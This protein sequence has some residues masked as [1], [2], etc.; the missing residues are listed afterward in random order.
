MGKFQGA[1]EISIAKLNP[2]TKRPVSAFRFLGCVDSFDPKFAVQKGA[3][4]FERCSGLGLLDDQKIKS[5]SG[6]VDLTFTEWSTGNIAWMLNGGIVPQ[7]AP[8]VAAIETLPDDIVDGDQWHL[9]ASSGVTRMNITA[10]T[11]TDSASVPSALVL[12][13]HY[14]LDP[15]YGTIKFL[16]VST[17]VQPFVTNAYGYTD[18]EAV[19]MLNAPGAQYMLRFNTL[20]VFND[21]A[22]GVEELY[23]VQFDPIASLPGISDDFATF[24]MSGT[25]YADLTRA[26][27]AEYGR[28]GRVIPLAEAV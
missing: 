9:G 21:L 2:S 22:K 18:P 15:I 24:S 28:F 1:G 16:D 23:I 8:A 14:S 3:E 17:K 25:T 5:V 10:L 20:N 13:T 27:D 6:S 12:N 4:H 7:G 19:P 11:L 26:V